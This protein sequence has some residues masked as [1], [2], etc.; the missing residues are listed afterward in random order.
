MWFWLYWVPPG[1]LLLNGMPHLLAGR[2]GVPFKS[3]FGRPSRPRTNVAW[4]LTN[5]GTASTIVTLHLVSDVPSRQD[6]VGLLLGAALA[7]AH[8]SL[9][10]KTFYSDTARGEKVPG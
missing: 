3:P 5:L 4:G 7:A 8:F 6:V 1:F 2:A 10:A 9:R